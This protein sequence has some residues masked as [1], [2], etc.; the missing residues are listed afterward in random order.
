MVRQVCVQVPVWIDQCPI[1]P[2]IWSSELQKL[3][4]HTNEVNAVAFSPDG[5]LLVSASDDETV[6]VWDA[7]TGQEVQNLKVTGYINKLSF[8]PDGSALNTDRGRLRICAVDSSAG[9]S[10]LSIEDSLTINN[11][12]V[13]HK[14]RKLLWLPQDYRSGVCALHGYSV[15]DW[16]E[17]WDC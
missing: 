14:G 2:T 16:A 5:S 4:G 13:E 7:S 9:P 6:R 17:Q 8:T 10:G 11:D 12:W 3:E 15:R 1:T